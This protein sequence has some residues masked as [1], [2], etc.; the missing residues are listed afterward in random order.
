MLERLRLSV[1]KSR[2][3]RWGMG[4]STHWEERCRIVFEERNWKR[5]LGVHLHRWKNDTEMDLNEI[6]LNLSGIEWGSVAGPP[7]SFS[8]NAGEIV[9]RWATVRF[10]R[11]PVLRGVS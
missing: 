2:R 9:I 3:A 8:I 6:G 7:K 11:T 4:C 10:S 5:S 1:L